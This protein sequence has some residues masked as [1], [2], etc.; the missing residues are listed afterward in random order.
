MRP[1]PLAAQA[2]LLGRGSPPWQG[3][4]PGAG[5]SAARRWLRPSD[6]LARVMRAPSQSRRL[7][8]APRLAQGLSGRPSSN[9]RVRELRHDKFERC[10]RSSPRT[11]RWPSP[12]E[13]P[14]LRLGGQRQR[15]RQS[16]LRHRQ[17]LAAADLLRQRFVAPQR[18]RPQAS[19]RLRSPSS[20][21]T[22]REQQGRAP[23]APK[24]ELGALPPTCATP[25]VNRRQPKKRL[26]ATMRRMRK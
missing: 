22:R 6:R 1:E 20:S 11:P 10:P 4:R 23:G 9:R 5:R 16:H 19:S 7:G 24:Q 25:Q 8:Y 3:R 14:H 13:T 12:A 15:G 17:S 18:A 2:K 21:A 26:V